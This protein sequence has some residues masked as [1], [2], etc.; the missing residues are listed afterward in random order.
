MY[1]QIART[2]ALDRGLSSF[3]T[4]RLLAL[5]NVAMADAAIA[6]W[7]SKFFYDYWRPVTA[8]QRG[9]EDG[10]DATIVVPDYKPLGAP[11]SNTAGPNFTPPFPAYPS[12]HAT[13]GG[14]VFQVLRDYFGTDDISF[15][16][17]SDE[18]NGVTQDVDG[19]VREYRPRKFSSLSEAEE[20]NDQSRIYLGIHW[21]FDK[22]GG[23]A[24]GN[25]IADHVIRNAF[26]PQS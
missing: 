13:F 17:V 4:A 14:V 16:F 10:N 3:E 9:D 22:I 1:N 11:R 25:E 15:T 18:Y 6:S 8:I 5:L 12:G 20:E 7:D 19:S 23:I 2:V 24:M 26:Q 21:E